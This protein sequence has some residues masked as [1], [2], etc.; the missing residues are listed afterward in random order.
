MAAEKLPEKIFLT[1]FMGAGKTSAG[2]ALARRLGVRFR[3]LDEFIALREGMSIGDIFSS[4]GEDGF[5]EAESAA[6]AGICSA[7]GP[8]VVSTGGGAVISER[9]RRAMERAGVVIYLKAKLETLMRRVSLDAPRPLL[10]V[11]DPAARAAELLAARASFYE[12]ADFIIETD[13]LSP[14]RVADRAEEI[15][16]G[17]QRSLK[18]R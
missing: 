17:A 10:K 14:E 12:D 15:L 1:G 9:N 2:R 8:A 13:G 7:T 11:E 6:L 5:R 18:K 4:S 3:D 16:R